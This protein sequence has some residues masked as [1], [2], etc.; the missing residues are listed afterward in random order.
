MSNDIY[1]NTIRGIGWSVLRTPEFN[2]IVQTSPSFQETTIIQANN[3]RWHW[4]LKYNY[5]KDN[6]ADLVSGLYY[7]DFQT[8]LAFFLSH[9]GQGIN[10]L[11]NDTQTPDYYVGPALIGVAPNLNAQLQVIYNTADSYYYSPLQVKRGGVWYEDIDYLNGAIAAYGNGTLIN[12]ANYSVLGPGLGIPGY[13][14]AGMYVKWTSLPAV[15][16][17]AQFNF[18][19]RVRF[20]SDQQEFEKFLNM[21]WAAGGSTGGASIKF[22]SARAYA[23][24]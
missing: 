4:E 21:L 6:T 24:E 11:F 18:C 5:L 3:P 23:V 10:F 15:P 19:W 9:Y 12:S 7:T 1:P 22:R 8:L 13:S 16:V 20:D 17:T 14:F 2:T